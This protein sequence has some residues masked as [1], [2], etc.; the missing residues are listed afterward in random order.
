MA[1]KRHAQRKPASQ[2]VTPEQ[3]LLFVEL[4]E[5]SDDWDGLGLDPDDDMW[6]L[7]T[8]IMHSPTAAPVSQGTGGLR[9]LRF[10]PSSWSS[11]KSGA[12]RVCYAYFARHWT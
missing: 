10:V 9:K 11:G 7:C 8:Q 3:F 5:F 4:D 2:L 6:E 12:I 1:K